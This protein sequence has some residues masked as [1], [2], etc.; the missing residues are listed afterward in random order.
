[1]SLI[2]DKL[3]TFAR[4]FE[5]TIAIINLV[6]VAQ[7]FEAICIGIF[8]HCF[9]TRSIENSLLELVSTYFNII[10]TNDQEMLHLHYF[11]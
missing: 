10:K 8:K 2:D 5:R 7:F 6:A 11:V 3:T 1:M 4:E 9:A